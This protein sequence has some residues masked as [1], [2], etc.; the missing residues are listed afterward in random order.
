MVQ[1]RQPVEDETS[2]AGLISML[3]GLSTLIG[4]VRTPVRFTSA[5]TEEGQHGTRQA[6]GDQREDVSKQQPCD[7]GSDRKQL[8]RLVRCGSR[9]RVT[10]AGDVARSKAQGD[11]GAGNRASN[12]ARA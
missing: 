9:V 5:P 6:G 10:V 12:P 8:S 11:R 3:R 7:Q 1:P 4:R 2:L